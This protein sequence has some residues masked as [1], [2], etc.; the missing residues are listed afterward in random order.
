MSNINRTRKTR[1]KDEN[2][3]YLLYTTVILLPIKLDLIK[4]FFFVSDNEITIK[5]NQNRKSNLIERIDVGMFC[6]YMCIVVEE[7]PHTKFLCVFRF[8]FYYIWINFIAKLLF[9]FQD[10]YYKIQSNKIL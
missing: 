3:T 8:L 4:N 6:I 7:K 5:K 1:G 10:L 2:E 9:F